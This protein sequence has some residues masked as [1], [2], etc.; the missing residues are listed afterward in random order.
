M[1]NYGQQLTMNKKAFLRAGH[2]PAPTNENV[3]I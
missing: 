3:L 1:N 2:R